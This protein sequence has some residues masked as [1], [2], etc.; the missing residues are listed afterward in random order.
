MAKITMQLEGFKKLRLA[1]RSVSLGRAAEEIS[2]ELYQVG[3]E[4]MTES[5]GLVPVD[6]GALRASGQVGLPVST[7]Q[8]ITV[9]LG[10][11]DT[12]VTYAIPVHERMD[13]K[14]APPTGAKYLERPALAAAKNLVAAVSR[15]A[16]ASVTKAVANAPRDE[17]RNQEA[18][19]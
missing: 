4:I 5:K 16:A 10:Y 11:G 7:D 8:A 19:E 14:H 17:G 1:L 2:K 3:N 18:G 13:V 6:T 12:A 15:G 9:E